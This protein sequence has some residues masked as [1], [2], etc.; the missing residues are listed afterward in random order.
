MAAPMTSKTIKSFVPPSAVEAEIVISP[1]ADPHIVLTEVAR[2]F[3]L[4]FGL[5]PDF[6]ELEVDKRRAG[7]PAPGELATLELGEQGFFAY[8]AESG[9][10]L[11]TRVGPRCSRRG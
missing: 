1:A 6:W 9:D 8:G 11:L 5:Q 2:E 10:I 4:R 3:V 7:F